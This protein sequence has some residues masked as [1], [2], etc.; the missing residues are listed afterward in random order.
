MWKTGGLP[1]Y[2]IGQ[3]GQRAPLEVQGLLG[4]LNAHCL[5]ADLVPGLQL[6]Q[7]A[8]DAVVACGVKIRRMYVQKN[9]FVGVCFVF[10]GVF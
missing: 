2:H 10:C 3:Q 6:G 8:V 1:L 5:K 4:G 7:Q 9:A